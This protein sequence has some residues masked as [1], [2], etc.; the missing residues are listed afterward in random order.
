V[1]LPGDGRDHVVSNV[2]P[3]PRYLRLRG[4]LAIDI[5]PEHLIAALL[6]LKSE[7][8]FKCRR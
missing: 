1:Q 4:Y 6:R 5:E 8:V 2:F 7:L 3:G